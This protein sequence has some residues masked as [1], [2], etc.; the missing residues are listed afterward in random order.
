MITNFKIFENKDFEKY[1]DKFCIIHFGGEDYI[2]V[3]VTEIMKN[4]QVKFAYYSY[5][6][7]FGEVRYKGSTDINFKLFND[8][9]VYDTFEE[10]EKKY[11][12]LLN[13]KKYNI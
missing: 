1:L 10:A 2:L 6:E 11:L 13:A 7:K 5:D 8:I 4:N 9:G 3:H 12:L